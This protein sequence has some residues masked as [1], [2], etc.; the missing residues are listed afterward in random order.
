MHSPDWPAF[1]IEHMKRRFL[2]VL[3]VVVCAIAA[4]A[5][6]PNAKHNSA[7]GCTIQVRD[8]VWSPTKPAIVQGKVENLTERAVEV[9]VQPIL[10]LR[11]KTSSAE[12]D[13]YWGPVDLL[14]NG[15][16]GLD[17]QPMDRKGDV[18]AI[19]ALPIKLVFGSKRQSID[20][21]IDA[22]HVLWDREVSSVWPSRELFAAVA[23]GAYDL[24]LVL[25]T[26]TGDSESANLTVQIDAHH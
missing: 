11:S 24:R 25:E 18:V 4:S 10:Y 8:P 1:T 26:D 20:F 5:Q 9:R 2:N 21:T 12:R 3:P 17:K 7:I 23:P 14:R 19:R 15:P 22:R 6:S 16:L 13:S